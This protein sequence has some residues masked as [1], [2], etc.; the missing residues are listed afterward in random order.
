M[1][2]KVGWANH[3]GGWVE[4]FCNQRTS[5]TVFIVVLPLISFPIMMKN[6]CF[7]QSPKR[8]MTIWETQFFI[9]LSHFQQ[10]W[11]V[12][13]RWGNVPFS[14]ALTSAWWIFMSSSL[15]EEPLQNPRALAVKGSAP[16]LGESF[17]FPL[18]NWLI[19][20]LQFSCLERGFCSFLSVS[21]FLWLLL[22][23]TNCT[24]F[25]TAQEH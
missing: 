7:L 19:A 25:S 1:P 13:C 18:G 20:C 21:R 11:N 8:F 6:L 15:Y 2:V 23:L 22:G 3:L 9:D 4:P 14:R 16:F 5:P 17:C 24:G 12:L 10:L